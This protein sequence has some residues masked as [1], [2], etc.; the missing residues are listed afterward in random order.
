MRKMPHNVGRRRKSEPDFDVALSFAG[1]DRKYVEEVATTLKEMGFRVFYDKYETVS[2]WGKDL[3]LHLREIYFKRA[4]YTVIFISKHYRKKLW[5]NHERESAQARAFQESSEYVLPARFDKTKIPGLLP[6]T[7]Y[8]DLS[9]VTPF[10]LADLI[11]RKIGPLRRKEFFPETPD[12]L[13][14][15]LRIRQQFKRKREFISELARG[16]FGELKLMTPLERQVLATAVNETCPTGPPDNVHLSINLLARYTS[17]TPDE[18]KSLFSRLDCLSIRTTI[19]PKG[20]RHGHCN[21]LSGAD[22]IIRITYEPS[23]TYFHGNASFIMIGIFRCIFEYQ[24]PEC[25]KE[26]LE[27]LDFSILSTLAGSPDSD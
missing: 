27:L 16:F 9:T 18:L 23:S 21:E 2:L 1:E 11:K 5:A 3:Y 7:G 25:R 24:C 13:L 19:D 12:R 8:I 17:K 20:Q 22:E 26:A 14:Q 15:V 10:E 4:R 6:T